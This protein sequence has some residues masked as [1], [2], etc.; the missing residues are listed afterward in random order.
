[1][2]WKRLALQAHLKYILQILDCGAPIASNPFFALALK[3][4][5]SYSIDPFNN[6]FNFDTDNAGGIYCLVDSKTAINP[7]WSE[8]V[9]A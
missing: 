1:M 6:Q 9:L 3:P 2:L 7:H 4:N 5:H 8:H